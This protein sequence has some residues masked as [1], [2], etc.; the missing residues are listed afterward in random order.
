[1][2]SIYLFNEKAL[3]A[4]GSYVGQDTL[5]A[6]DLDGTLAPIVAEYSTAQVDEPVRSA[7][8]RLVNLAK[9]AVITGRARKDAKTILGFGPQLL[10][11][12]HG[13][14]WPF[15]SESRNQEF[16]HCC[17]LWNNQLHEELQAIH[18][19]EIEFKGESLS[20][21]YRKALG[22]ES[23]RARIDTAIGKL[24]PTPRI[25][26]G[27]FVVNLL[28]IEAFTKGEAL[29]AALD[30]FGLSRAI[31]FGDDI[32]DEE[33]FRLKSTDLLG[34]HIGKDEYTAASYYLNSQ[35]ELLGLLHSIV[36]ILE[37]KYDNVVK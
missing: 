22:Q 9:V 28:P 33:V 14:E 1:M 15:G 12:N 25:I 29:V 3:K 10:V 17:T 23:A 18:G 31:Y 7:M 35:S 32:T 30:K 36:G 26:G 24:V 11:G 16:I 21:H 13:A 34:I 20:I 4:F 8:D 19:V 5:F 2:T 27:K 6:F 37:S